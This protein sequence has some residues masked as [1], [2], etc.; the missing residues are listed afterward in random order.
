MEG[1]HLSTKYYIFAV[2]DRNKD[3]Q[4]EH[5]QMIYEPQLHLSISFGSLIGFPRSRQYKLPLTVTQQDGLD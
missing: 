3:L 4:A 2:D 1:V 5:F